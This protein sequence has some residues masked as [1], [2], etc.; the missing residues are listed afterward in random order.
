M[1]NHPWRIAAIVI[2][3]AIL[4]LIAYYLA[5]DADSYV[6][7]FGYEFGLRF[8]LAAVAQGLSLF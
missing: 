1:P 5:V 8:L 7:S 2:H 4:A 6:L 3:L